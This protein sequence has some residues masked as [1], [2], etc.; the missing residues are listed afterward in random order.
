MKIALAHNLKRSA[1]E[2][3]AFERFRPDLA[4]ADVLACVVES[5]P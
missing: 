1:C 4:P 3:E 2:E 5:V